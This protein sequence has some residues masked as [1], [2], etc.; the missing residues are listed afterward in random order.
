MLLR[1]SDSTPSIKHFVDLIYDVEPSSIDMDNLKAIIRDKAWQELPEALTLKERPTF[2]CLSQ[3]CLLP[4][5]NGKL[6]VLKHYYVKSDKVKGAYVAKRV[7]KARRLL[8]PP[9]TNSKLAVASSGCWSAWV[10]IS[11]V[12]SLFPLRRSD[13]TKHVPLKE[14][15]N[16]MQDGTSSSATVRETRRT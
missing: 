11:F 6:C 15:M 16:R 10:G 2:S 7:V 13:P 3:F 5:T 12:T 8:G 4:Q 1:L 9:S 14:K